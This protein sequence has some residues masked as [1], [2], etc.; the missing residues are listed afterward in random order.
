[1]KAELQAIEAN[2]TWILVS[3]PPG[4]HTIGCRWGYKVKYHLNGL[5]NK[6][7]ARLVAKGYTQQTGLDLIET[8]S[9][10]AKLTTSWVLLSLVA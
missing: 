2:S 10:V 5:V 9:L 8:F 1:M 7:K 3:L 4:K 6:Y